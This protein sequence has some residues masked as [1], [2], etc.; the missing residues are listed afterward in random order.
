M[1][2]GEKLLKNEKEE[3]GFEEVEETGRE[4]GAD[5]EE[6]KGSEEEEGGRPRKDSMR[7]RR[8]VSKSSV[9]RSQDVTLSFVILSFCLNVRMF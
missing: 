5:E 7:D 3:E 6:T 8:F 9:T 2:G 1:R 4:E